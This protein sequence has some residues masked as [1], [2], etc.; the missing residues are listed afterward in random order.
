MNKI[1]GFTINI[2]H[3]LKSGVGMVEM[4]LLA[5]QFLYGKI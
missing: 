2:E 5:M 1:P 3:N 4:N